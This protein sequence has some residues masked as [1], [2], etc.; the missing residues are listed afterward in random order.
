MSYHRESFRPGQ[1]DNINNNDKSDFLDLELAILYLLSIIYIR[2]T[3]SHE[4][5][6]I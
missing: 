1:Y 2:A 3:V 5:L 6:D 4:D